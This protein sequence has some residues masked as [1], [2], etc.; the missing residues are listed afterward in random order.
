MRSVEIQKTL[1]LQKVTK[2][3]YTFSIEVVLVSMSVSLKKATKKTN[4]RHNNRTMNEKEKEKNSHIDYSRSH[5]NKYLVQKDLKEIYR[6]EFSQ[7]L[8]NYNE[9]QKRADRKIDDYYKHI[10]SSKKTALQQEMIVQIGD[11]DDFSSKEKKDMA[12]EILQEWFLGFE[13]RNP[14]LKIYNAVIHNDEATPHMHLNFVPV[15]TGYKRGLEKQVAFD[16][17]ITQQDETLNK[18]RPFDDWREKE[19]RLL[20]KMLLERGIERKFVGTNEYQ[21][22][23]E[24]KKKMRELELIEKDLKAKKDELLKL[25]EELPVDLKIVAKKEF[26]KVEVK[27][28][29]K[30]MFGMAKTEFVRK[31]TG[32]VVISVD[33]YKK[34]L[35]LSKRNE[36]MKNKVKKILSTDF[37]KENR[38][39]QTDNA[40]LFAD[41]KSKAIENIRLKE[42]N[43]T[44]KNENRLLTSKMASIRLGINLAYKTIKD[45]F[46]SHTDSIMASRELFNNFIYM[47]KGNDPKNEFVKICQQEQDEEK[48]K[49][50]S[51]FS[52]KG[53][54]Q[55][56]SQQRD[57]Q[58]SVKKKNRDRGMDR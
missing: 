3:C 18:E 29:E 15:A 48:K 41:L 50:S 45:F 14:N 46:K 10:Q 24:F 19:V 51:M 5:E 30:N 6:D 16:K 25:N 4:I 40:V 28:K 13:K 17:A 53:V 9:K 39:L 55:I 22:V 42:D 37:A 43:L 26:K 44:L 21:D 31:E 52:M 47:V 12:N 27:S 2:V 49:A 58:Q 1:L 7:A 20:E 11:K 56:D 36:E 54:K 34:L 33:D 38:K 8:K 35:R 57:M 23:T 32:N